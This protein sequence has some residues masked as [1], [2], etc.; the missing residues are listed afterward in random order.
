MSDNQQNPQAQMPQYEHY[1]RR[2]QKKNNWW[3]PVVIV[4]S[5]FALLVILVVGFFTL[6][7]STIGSAFEKEPVVVRNNSI[8]HLSMANVQEYTRATGFSAFFSDEKPA[9]LRDI[10]NALIA[11]KTDDRIKGIY[12]EPS[13]VGSGF[14]KRIEVL[15]ALEDF[16]KSGKFIYAFIEVGDENAYINA[17]PADSIF[18]P[19]EGMLEMN[20]YGSS[21]L[22]FKGLAEKVG[23]DFYVQQFEDFKSA[24]EM[25]SRKSF[26]DS[27]RLQT[28]VLLNHRYQTLLNLIEKYRGIDKETL[29]SLFNKGLFNADDILQAG[30]IDAIAPEYRVKDM[31]KNLVKDGESEDNKNSKV[32]L[33][34]IS[35]YI[36]SSPKIEGKVAETD[37]KIAIVYGS[38]AIT[39]GES[40]DNPFSS[41]DGIKSGTFIKN[42]RKAAEDDNVAA[43]IV[44]IDSPGGSVIASDEIWEELKRT[45]VKRPDVPI[46]ASMADVAASG[47]FYMAVGCDSIIA[48]PT[49]ITGSIGVILSIPNLSGL[50][51]NLG[52]SSDTISTTNSAQFL[53]G[54]MP[55][56]QTD[57]D[58]LYSMSQKIY[59]RFLGKVAQHRNMPVDELR[60][61]AKGRVWTGEDAFKLG[62]IDKLG[63]LQ[64]VINMA[65]AR[66][67][68]PINELV[69]IEEYPRSTDDVEELLQ[70]LT[71]G[72]KEEELEAS[73]AQTVAKYLPYANSETGLIL[74]AMPAPIRKQLF[75]NIE[76]LEMAQKE[77]VLVAMPSL[78]E[79]Q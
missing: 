54:T 68:V 64:D 24:G 42:L 39:S 44:R 25:Y 73:L 7:G 48:H 58:K 3:I 22:F 49:T 15:D 47:G 33:L 66:I 4:L 50:M 41:S 19:A 9:S 56:S 18:M 71:G 57:K 55:F 17:L 77:K 13:L 52:V 29:N 62:L 27:A 46:Y 26:S 79:I 23:V 14:T 63:G 43:I 2:K 40:D 28:Q 21:P 45:K 65:K 61:Y 67:G 6:I 16:K 76:L 35:K 72:S 51:N 36:N 11:A 38:G 53:N 37:K 59:F 32:R 1:Q 10:I 74:K 31:M 20:G 5:V 8:L 75:Y 78:L 12:Y 34:S 60:Q 30:L 70:K 69:T